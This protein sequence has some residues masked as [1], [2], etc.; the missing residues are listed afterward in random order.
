MST[1]NKGIRLI[2]V[3]LDHT[4]LDG[5]LQV[6]ERNRRALALAAQEDV[7]V[8]IATGRTHSSARKY[9][10][11]LEIEAPVISYNGAMIRGASA[12]EPMRHV[13]LPA[14][15][16]AEIVDLLVE[17]QI[18]LM[19]FID[20]SIYAPRFDRWAYEYLQRTGDRAQIFGDLRRMAGKEPTKL[21]LL[22]TPEQTQ[23]RYEFF[24]DHYGDRVYATISLPQYMELLNPEATKAS[25][26][27]WLADHLDVPMEQTMAL[28]D[29]LNDL[30]MVEAAG[31]GVFMARADEQLRQ[32]ADFVP[33]DER[34]GVAEAVERFVL[35]GVVGGDGG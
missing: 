21:L 3:D 35:D 6:S 15:L 2:A 4:L 9:A 5:D 18:D 16:A 12:D 32:Q 23:E 11:D 14:D 19:Y 33:D 27:R 13:P 25:A 10:L 22:G 17:K 29:S 31:V 8:A 30:E 34:D 24:T 1:T 7:T 20:D 28:G 26:L